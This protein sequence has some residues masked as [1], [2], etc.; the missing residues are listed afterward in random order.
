MVIDNADNQDVFFPPQSE[1]TQ[2]TNAA[3]NLITPLSRY[4]PQTSNSG[5][6]LITSRTREAAYYLTNSDERIIQVPFMNKAD[7][8][9]L[10]CRKMEAMCD[11]IDRSND[12]EKIELV[13]RLDCLPLAIT[14]ATSYIIVRKR[15]MTIPKYSKFLE[16]NEEILLARV[17]DNR[18]DP[19]YPN[20]ILLTLQISFDQIDKDSKPAIELLS[21]MSVL[22]RQ[23]IPR[24]LLRGE[25][26]DDLDFEKRLDALIAFSLITSDENNQNFQIHRL[27]QVA[28]Q[29]WLKRDRTLDRFKRQAL[30]VIVKNFP[31]TPWRFW[32]T[33]E[34]LLPHANTALTYA[35]PDRKMQLLHAK[36][37][38]NIV[39]YYSVHGKY[40]LSVALSNRVFEIYLDLLGEAD[41]RT[42]HA[43]VHLGSQERRHAKSVGQAMSSRHESMLRKMIGVFHERAVLEDLRFEIAKILLN[44]GDDVRIDEAIELLESMLN[45]RRDT[46]RT[47][48]DLTVTI[49]SRLAEAYMK[50]GRLAE[51]ADI[52][53]EVLDTRLRI[54]PE[55]DSRITFSLDGLAA[56]MLRLNRTKE[57]YDFGKQSLDLRIRFYGEEH[58]Q[59]LRAVRRL[60]EIWS[61]WSVHDE[62]K[63][64]EAYEFCRNAMDLHLSVLG[65]EDER[66]IICITHLVRILGAKNKYDEAEDLQRHVIDLDTAVHGPQAWKTTEDMMGLTRI[67]RDQGKYEKA[68]EV[69]R[70]LLDMDLTEWSSSKKDKLY[71]R[72]A[73]TLRALGRHEEAKEIENLRTST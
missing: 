36:L 13:E 71:R 8:T 39:K 69:C 15:T 60:V 62:N 35:N 28:V 34:D 46:Q 31:A 48:P 2:P 43:L 24:M 7:A 32:E 51:A 9:T 23:G 20:S 19:S 38:E 37:S 42:A 64:E 11:P 21:F 47:K 49:M 30:N 25:D 70:K 65:E 50:R 27:V 58:L 53:Q 45:F 22:D 44:S 54:Y 72:F 4:L 5:L 3:H 16:E 55:N 73:R 6:M 14:Q 12:I 18:R 40:D 56:I 68:E 26:E 29:S 41:D 33:W 1:T 61:H 52:E 10:L 66:T 59:T 17:P 63:R 57:A 67:L